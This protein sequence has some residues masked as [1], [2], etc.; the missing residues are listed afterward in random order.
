[1]K[2]AT[3]KFEV[4]E[5]GPEGHVKSIV[6]TPEIVI[7]NWPL[8][9]DKVIAVEQEPVKTTEEYLRRMQ[10]ASETLDRPVEIDVVPAIAGG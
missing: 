2:K 3:R 8:A 10:H 1:M 4:R 6:T 7:E 9:P 5:A